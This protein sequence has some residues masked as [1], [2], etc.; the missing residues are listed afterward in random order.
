MDLPFATDLHTTLQITWPS[1]GNIILY[2][3]NINMKEDTIILYQ[4]YNDS[5]ANYAVSNQT[6]KHCPDFNTTRM[7]WLKPNFLWMMYRS[8]WAT[9]PNQERILAI[10]VKKG[11]FNEILRKSVSTAEVRSEKPDVRLQWDPDHDPFGEKLQ[12]RAIQIGIRGNVLD[13]F[14]SQHI[15]SI[16]DI[17]PFV[18]EQSNNVNTDKLEFLRVPAE[19]IYTIDDESLRNHIRL[20]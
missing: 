1:Q 12:R 10:T 19:H 6:F 8:G 3:P 5:I 16:C 18:R 17:T 9:K 7:T 20:D 13:T 14:L 4:A 2:S 15:V 11:D